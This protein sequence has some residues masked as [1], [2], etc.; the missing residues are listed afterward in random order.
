MANLE[1]HGCPGHESFPR[2]GSQGHSA[3][4]VVQLDVGAR[5]EDEEVNRKM[6][7]EGRSQQGG[8]KLR[9]GLGRPVPQAPH[10]RKHVQLV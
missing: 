2:E 6:G 5:R 1:E 4:E 9:E 10:W 8:G 3:G 7:E